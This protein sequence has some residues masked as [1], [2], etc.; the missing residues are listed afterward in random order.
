MKREIKHGLRALGSSIVMLGASTTASTVYAE[1][2][3]SVAII[4]FA[5]YAPWYI[6]D[7]RGLAENIDLDV[8]IIES[9]QG[10]NAAISTGSVQCMNN[11]VD[12]MV[13]ARSNGVP[14][15]LVAYSNMSYGLDKMVATEE[16]EGVEDFPGKTYGADLG[17]LNHM[18]ML[19][20]LERA[21]F[22]YDAAELTVLLPQES[23]A[24]FLS[25][26]I[27]IDVNYLP[28]VAQSLEREGAH[29]LKSSLSDRTWERGLIGDAI[30][31]NAEWLDEN[32]ETATELLRAWF[33]AVNWWK[34]NPEKGN[35][36]VAEGLGWEVG[37]VRLNMFGAVE[38]NL[39]QNLGA[40]GLSGGK[41][42]CKSLPSGVPR[43][44]S[45][46]EGWGDLFNGKDCVNGYAAPT[47]NV[48]NEIYAEVGVANT[49]VPAEQ[50]LNTE[51]VERLREEGG[52]EKF[53]SNKWIGRTGLP[54]EYDVP[55]LWQGIRAE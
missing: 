26:S 28:F 18:W 40:F 38:L 43:A 39:S 16:I 25:E 8:K 7:E 37:D 3:V 9:I 17:F 41:A 21:G 29:V 11:T 6:V 30:A 14:M 54:A 5:P 44:P 24:A 47:W 33:E 4:S 12:S 15:E 45:D 49:E 13:S 20:T 52:V 55:E 10:K 36:I 35:E 1:E 34:E 53:G 51:I 48:F 50:A 22:A 23:A 19:L 32:P 31:C 27:D 2:S 46:T 42:L